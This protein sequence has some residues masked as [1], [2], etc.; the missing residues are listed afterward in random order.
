M[1]QQ[2]PLTPP[3]KLAEQVRLALA[4]DVGNGDRTAALVPADQQADATIIARD[5]AV[6]CGRAW[7]EAAF[8]QTDPAIAVQWHLSEG[9]RAQAGQTLCELQ[10][11]ARGL[12][13]A[14]RTALNFLQTLSATATAARRYVDAVAGTG[15]IILDT[16]KTLP[17]LRLAQKYAVRCGGASNH[18]IGLFDAIL[19]KENHI[20]AA[21]GIA[22]AAN[23]AR[24][25][26][27]LVEI[28][29]ENMA[30]LDEALQVSADRLLLDNFSAADLG[31]AVQK[32]DARAPEIQLE[33]S[34]GITLA[35]I[36]SIAESGVDFI[37]VGALTKDVQAVDL[38][39]RFRF[40]C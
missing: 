21:G 16:R 13:T 26:G 19:I 30:Q 34:G 31:T 12:L 4:E 11:P 20:A 10:G 32:R 40:S 22:A 7:V 24:S 38:S 8:T 14:E 35:N 39:M 6:L 9:E 25:S 23:A 33:A 27:V 17:G 3:A 15:T 5:E 18:R 28:E 29:V 2:E 36:R 37:S 1:I